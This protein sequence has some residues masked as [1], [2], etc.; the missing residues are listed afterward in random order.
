MKTAFITVTLFILSAAFIQ[1]VT[2]STKDFERAKGSWTGSLT[3]L[4]YTSGKPY[5]MPANINFQV[6]SQHNNQLIFQ[7][8]YPDEPKA[9]GYDT[10]TISHNGTQLNNAIVTANTFIKNLTTIVTE[11]K[12][13]DGNDRKPAIIK[14]T[15]IISKDSFAI[16]KEVQFTGTTNWLLRNTYNFHRN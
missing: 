4:D 13:I 10:L 2:I 15:Y 6:N 12:A 14:H 16:R 5:T 1:S 7:Y 11:E 8:V 3:Y 9:N